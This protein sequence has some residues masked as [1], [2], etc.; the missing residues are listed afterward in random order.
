MSTV[1]Q[2]P[3]RFGILGYLGQVAKALTPSERRRA[4]LMFVVIVALHLI[5]FVVFIVFVVPGHYKG[6]G[7]GVAGLAYSLG[8]RHAF[9]ADHIS[10]IDNTTRKLM[11]EDKRP[12]SIGF[13]FSLGHSTIVIAIGVGIVIAEKAVYRAVSHND[14]GLEQFGGIFGTVVSAGFLYLIGILN[15]VIL[16]GIFRVFQ[17]MRKGTYD[18][19]ELERQL[20]NRGLMYR[21][22]GRWMKTIDKEWK[23]YPV[24]VVFGMG[25][26]TAT[27][28]ALLAT[29]ALLA[30]Q[31]LPF[32]AILCLPV[33][34]TAGM[35]LMDTIDGIFMN[36]AYSW[37]FFNPVRKVYY[38]LAITGLSVAIC[39]FIG[40]IEILGLLPA[41][42]SSL[43]GGFWDY[44]ANFDIN[45]AGFVIVGMFILTWAGALLFWKFGHVEERWNARLRTTSEEN[46]P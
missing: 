5:G 9:D 37:A 40:T 41:E 33:L 27:E 13:W 19:A 44:M 10:A 17:A 12:L 45:K 30:S 26:D 32:Y 15:L 28:V 2:P 8:L 6:L 20:Q 4:G 7:I 36:F 3:V 24:G 16:V 46:P 39:L 14:S 21:F 42:I 25:F 11:N 43:H 1:N 34:F 22:F 31:H 38:N 29:T 23:M 18:E 35:S